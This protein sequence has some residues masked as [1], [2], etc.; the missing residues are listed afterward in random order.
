MFAGTSVE[1][2]R[3]VR[4]KAIYIEYWKHVMFLAINC[5]AIL[6]FI[7]YLKA[8]SNKS[9]ISEAMQY[10]DHVKKFTDVHVDVPALV[11]LLRM[12]SSAIAL[13]SIYLLSHQLIY[14]YSSHRL[15]IYLNILLSCTCSALSGSRGGILEY[16]FA[17]VIMCYFIFKR[18]HSWKK[19]IPSRIVALIIIS[20]LMIIPV[21][22]MSAFLMGRGKQT[23]IFHYLCIYLSGSLKNFD[24][25]IRKGFFG[26]SIAD[27]QTLVNL[28]LTI[29]PKF[30][31]SGWNA[32]LDLPFNNVNGFSTGNV[33][34]IFY[35]FMYDGGYIA[36]VGYIIAMAV[37]ASILYVLIIKDRYDKYYDSI[38]IPLIVYTQ[39]AYAVLFSFF[40]D[41]FY[42]LI[43]DLGF[44]R[45][46]IIIVL[47]A[48]F[49]L[50]FRFVKSCEDYT[51]I[52][53]NRYTL[54]KRTYCV[55]RPEE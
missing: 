54:F 39:I 36:L 18:K 21:F 25:F 7:R 55:R 8:F 40:S 37:I 33:Y 14:G 3:K 4:G 52:T 27:S 48:W 30:G 5:A 2:D 24:I 23:D 10:F 26:T 50:R 13:I 31:L 49:A 53:T 12:S 34:T 11:S 20:I 15:F 22:Y 41:K 1:S 9:S 46:N 16:A 28:R 43:F 6:F 38:N 47:L 17:F 29:L 45:K 42:E 35:M 32:K 44:W 19:K 51:V